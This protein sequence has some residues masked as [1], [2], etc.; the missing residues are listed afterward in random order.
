MRAASAVWLL[1]A[2]G[3]PEA[4]DPCEGRRDLL[5]SDGGLAL[6]PAEH[7]QGWG[8]SACFQCHPSWTVH[9]TDCLE[10]VAIDG[11][12][13]DALRPVDCVPCH[14]PNGVSAWREVAP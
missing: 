10:G 7:P 14:G 2:A 12:A 6:G 11:D 9:T 1:L 8:R 3:C 13:I 4:P 5:A